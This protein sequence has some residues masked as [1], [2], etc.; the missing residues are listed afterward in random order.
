MQ[1]V[2]LLEYLRKGSSLLNN[3]YEE[4]DLEFWIFKV[5]VE[6]GLPGEPQI[7]DLSP[8][9][10]LC[11]CHC[12]LVQIRGLPN[13]EPLSPTVI[14]PLG[15]WVVNSHPS[16]RRV[17]AIAL[18]ILHLIVLISVRTGLENINGSALQQNGC[19]WFKSKIQ[20]HFSA[21]NE[22]CNAEWAA[23]ESPNERQRGSASLLLR[24]FMET[25][26]LR[27]ILFPILLVIHVFKV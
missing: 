26:G 6:G 15:K 13:T 8:C 9:L 25:F 2:W 12:G 18:F 27:Y 14:E 22:H 7:P 17:M 19:W 16:Q 3:A 5:R 23:A 20:N 10:C 4:R 11:L 1:G 24:W 21:Y